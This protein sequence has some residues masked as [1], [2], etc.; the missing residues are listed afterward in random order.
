MN[1]VPVKALA[2]AFSK[3]L[4]FSLSKYVT[5]NSGIYLRG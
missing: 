4:I 1:E 5:L 2:G 3:E